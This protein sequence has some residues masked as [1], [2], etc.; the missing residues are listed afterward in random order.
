MRL[1]SQ[2]VKVGLINALRTTPPAGVEAWR[3]RGHPSLGLRG[4]RALQRHREESEVR[5]PGG[6]VCVLLW[7]PGLRVPSVWPTGWQ[8]GQGHHGRLGSGHQV[9][10]SQ[11]GR[12][13]TGSRGPSLTW[14]RWQSTGRPPA[15]TWLFR[16]SKDRRGGRSCLGTSC[17]L[18]PPA[19]WPYCR[20]LDN[21]SPQPQWCRRCHSATQPCSLGPCNPAW[22]QTSGPRGCSRE[23][24][25]VG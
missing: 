24:M 15:T 9:S 20:A 3:G 4:G 18:P 5:A 21:G 6:C 17:S 16:A 11:A 1:A 19:H 10:N 2:A 25:G 22:L 23:E 13:S 7:G 8:H 12:A 14:P